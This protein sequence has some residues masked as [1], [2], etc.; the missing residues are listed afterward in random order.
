MDK[1]IVFATVE[2][3]RVVAAGMPVQYEIVWALVGLLGV[4]LSVALFRCRHFGD[5]D[6]INPH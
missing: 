2:H 4:A 3:V 5:N 1:S 6:L